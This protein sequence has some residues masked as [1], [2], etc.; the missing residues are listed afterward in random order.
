MKRF[1]VWSTVCAAVLLLTGC[2]TEEKTDPMTEEMT[3]TVAEG[4]DADYSACLKTY[5]EAVE[6][7]D[8]AAYQ[9]VVYPPYLEVYTE[10]LKESDKTP[11]SAF[12]TLCSRFDEDGYNSWHIAE[13]S[14]S[15][16]TGGEKD[17]ED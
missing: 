15:E 8:F 11:E 14:L 13:I 4:F 16:S 2:S 10:Y 12:E 7:K 9:S 6:N 1:C 17:I 5:F 3:V